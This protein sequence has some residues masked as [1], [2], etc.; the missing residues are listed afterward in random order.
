MDTVTLDATDRGLIHALQIDGR[1]PFRTVAEVL[2]VSENTVARR[3]RRLRSSGV[4]RVVGAVNGVRLGYTSWTLRVRCTPDAAGSIAGALAARRD[5]SYVHLLSGGTE[6]SCNVQTPTE[7][8]RDALLLGKLPRTSRVTEVS[9]HLLLRATALPTSWSGSAWLTEEQV[10][11]L[12]TVPASQAGEPV[13]LEEQDRALLEI[14]GREGR[15][16]YAELAAVAGS[17]D[18]TVKRRLDTLC[19]AGVL[20]FTVD[21]ASAA[22]GFPT[23]AR[24][25]MSVQ[26]SRLADVARTMADHPEISFAAMTTGPS[27]LL[28]AVNCRDAED[29][30]RYLT[31]RV[32]ALDGI[33]SIETAPVIRTLKGAGAYVHTAR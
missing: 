27:N 10:G 6:V 33:Q 22:L 26:P 20:T 12:R 16:S 29:L 28:A 4:L 24:L 9:A 30:C 32:A 14:L 5:T 25:W 21:V 18:S 1:V 13:T 19:R 2:G 23:E 11:R 7:A 31:E 8:E 3:Y 17:T 15:A